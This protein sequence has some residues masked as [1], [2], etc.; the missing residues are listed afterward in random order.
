LQRRHDLPDAAVDVFKGLVFLAVIG[1]EP[2]VQRLRMWALRDVLARD[3]LTG[4]AP[5]KEATPAL[6][7]AT[8]AQV[9]EPGSQR[10]TEP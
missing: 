10:G 1:S 5:A 2:Y 4:A 3:A 7:V 6:P 8:I 9:S